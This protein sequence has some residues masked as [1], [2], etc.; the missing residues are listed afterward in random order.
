[1]C[2][3]VCVCVSSLVCTVGII[4][5][6]KDLGF[7]GTLFFFSFFFFLTC[8]VGCLIMIVWTPAV[9]DVLYACVLHLHLFSAIE[10]VS[11]G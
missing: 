9:S 7:M 3:C 5:V 2:V 4:Y 1:M 11:R 10:H 6:Y 8:L